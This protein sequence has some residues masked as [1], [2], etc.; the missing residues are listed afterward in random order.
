MCNFRTSL[1]C[2]YTYNVYNHKTFNSLFEG[3]WILKSWNL[4]FV[5]IF[6]F[7][8]KMVSEDDQSK[9]ERVSCPLPQQR[10]DL[11]AHTKWRHF[12]NHIGKCAWRVIATMQRCDQRESQSDQERTVV[13]SPEPEEGR[14]CIRREDWKGLHIHQNY[15]TF[16]MHMYCLA[17]SRSIY[18]DRHMRYIWAAEALLGR[19]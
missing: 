12:V 5:V 14:A 7:K 13:R 1:V 9:R 18:C 11:L 2:L 4:F 15:D 6:Y 19:V 17:C 3:A 16:L 8:I 10:A